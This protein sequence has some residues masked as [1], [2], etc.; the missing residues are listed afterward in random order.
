MIESK[1]T[2]TFTVRLFPVL[3]IFAVVFWKIKSSFICVVCTFI[4]LY[5]LIQSGRK[6][7]KGSR[8]I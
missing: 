1:V 3:L 7:K 6:E 2:S 5:F 8:E 4:I